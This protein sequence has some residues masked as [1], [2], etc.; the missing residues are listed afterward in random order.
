MQ[1]KQKT[2]TMHK[3]LIS[4][5]L[6]LSFLNA[7]E[8]IA[9]V[10]VPEEYEYIDNLLSQAADQHKENTRM[11]HLINEI[12]LDFLTLLASRHEG[13]RKW[14]RSMEHLSERIKSLLSK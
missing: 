13:V 4:L 10:T 12:E 9:G 14:E 8:F 3:Y 6:S 7:C 11:L 5:F 1:Y 2:I